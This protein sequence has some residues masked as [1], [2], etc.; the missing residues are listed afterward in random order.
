ML[1]IDVRE[2]LKQKTADHP[3]M[4]PAGDRYFGD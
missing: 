3:H 4:S 2:P 1:E